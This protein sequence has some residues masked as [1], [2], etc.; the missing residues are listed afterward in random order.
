MAR[1]HDSGP[2]HKNEREIDSQPQTKTKIPEQA[3]ANLD[4][5]M[6]HVQ[7]VRQMMGR[8]VPDQRVANPYDDSGRSHFVH[9]Q[10]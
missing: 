4:L 9:K 7:F 10:P 8:Y 2:L 5:D 6:K 3:P 1:L